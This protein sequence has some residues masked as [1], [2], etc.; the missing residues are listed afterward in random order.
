M[1]MSIESEFIL[2]RWFCSCFGY[3]KNKVESLNKFKNF[4]LLQGYEL[5]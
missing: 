5:R 1:K 4:C 3:N 2:Y